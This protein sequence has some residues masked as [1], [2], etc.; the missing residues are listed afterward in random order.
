[1][2]TPLD[3]FHAHEIGFGR[4]DWTYADYFAAGL[5]DF[6]EQGYVNDGSPWRPSNER[7]YAAC[8]V[9]FHVPPGSARR[10]AWVAEPVSTPVI[11][12]RRA[13]A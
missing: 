11:D 1:M 7:H 6:A 3:S 8:F 13:A 9:D 5:R 4:G 2:T 10:K 12:N